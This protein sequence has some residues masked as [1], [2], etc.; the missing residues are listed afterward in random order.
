MPSIDSISAHNISRAYT[1][2]GTDATQSSAARSDKSHQHRQ[3]TQ[4]PQADSV[5]LSEG[6]KSLAA[7]R[8]AVQYSSDVREQKVADI[9]QQISDG[10]YSVSS[11][12]LARRML[13]DQSHQA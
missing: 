2:Q 11:R 9:K 13:A 5:S 3:A 1:S 8:E 7:A 4:A 12:V 6:A 10:T